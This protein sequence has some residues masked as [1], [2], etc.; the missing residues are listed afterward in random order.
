MDG[1]TLHCTDGRRVRLIGIDAPERD[2]GRGFAASRSAL[3]RLAPEGEQLRLE[4]D[5]ARSDRYGR[6][7]AYAWRGDTLV[8]EA[9]VAGGWALLYTVPPNVKHA[10]RLEAAQRRARD[11]RAGLWEGD[12]FRCAPSARR[13]REC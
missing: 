8:N 10:R 11:A 4:R 1:D 7:L 6:R 5:A 3:A 2:Q 12:D 9:L 13:R